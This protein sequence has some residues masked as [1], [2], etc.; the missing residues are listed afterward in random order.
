MM[1]A[2]TASLNASRRA[3]E[4]I[5]SGPGIVSISNSAA[6]AR[7]G[8][9]GCTPR[10][11]PLMTLNWRDTVSSLSRYTPFR[12]P[13]TGW[14]S[15]LSGDTDQSG[16][17]QAV[18]VEISRLKHL[19]HGSRRVIAPWNFEHR[20]MPMR[21]E[22]FAGY[23]IDA[24][25]T[26][27]LKRVEQTALG[28]R[29]PGQQGARDLRQ[30]VVLRTVHGADA[31]DGAPQ[32]V[33]RRQQVAAEGRRRVADGILTLTLRPLAR[34]LLIGEPPQQPILQLGHLTLRPRPLAADRRPGRRIARREGFVRRLVD[35]VG[36]AVPRWF[37]GARFG[38]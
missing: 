6:A 28:R 17:Q 5:S 15:L 34:I 38:R 8:S 12:F 13:D 36:N 16:A 2:K 27:F 23:R 10:E 11:W 32:V 31:L 1:I 21:V 25:H 7:R 26:V 3:G 22:R 29:D 20:L 18:M 19:R 4:G 30:I 37:R 14:L 35:D 33:H 9:M 24:A